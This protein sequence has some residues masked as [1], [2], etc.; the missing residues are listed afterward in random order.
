M[1]QHR[2]LGVNVPLF[3]LGEAV[4]D[5]NVLREAG[6][7]ANGAVYILPAPAQGEAA[8]RFAKA[9]QA[10]YGKKPELFAAEAYDI[11]HL[12]ADAVKANPGK[13]LNG[14]LFRDYLYTVK[15]YQ[16]ASGTITFDKNGDV[17]K[18]MAIKV[19]ENGQPK[20]LEVV[21]AEAGAEQEAAAPLKKAA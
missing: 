7:A 4:E 10:K 5:P 17:L 14:E 8:E 6:D 9:Y 13:P 2:E 1:K 19:I 18:P 20:L 11:V 21:G 12:I 15:G 16:G 3:F